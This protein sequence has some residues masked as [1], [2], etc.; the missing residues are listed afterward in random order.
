MEVGDTFIAIVVMLLILL[1]IKW[2]FEKPNFGKC[3]DGGEHEWTG[4]YSTGDM[5]VYDSYNDCKKCGY[6][7][8]HDDSAYYS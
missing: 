3:P 7:R 4:W 8:I 1:F 5:S 6:R 2:L